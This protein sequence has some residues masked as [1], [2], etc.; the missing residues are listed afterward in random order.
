MDLDV[1]LGQ[2]IPTTN[3]R[4]QN[5]KF[6][7]KAVSIFNLLSYQAQNAR[8]SLQASKHVPKMKKLVQYAKDARIIK[9]F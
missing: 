8:K 4:T 5:A 2:S 3:L 7:G 6:R 9:Q 1:P